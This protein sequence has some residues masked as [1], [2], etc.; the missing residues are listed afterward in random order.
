MAIRWQNSFSIGFLTAILCVY[1]HVCKTSLGMTFATPLQDK[2]FVQDKGNILQFYNCMQVIEYFKIALL[3]C[4]HD[5]F[6]QTQYKY[7]RDVS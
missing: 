1:T 7:Y 6:L 2:S 5:R 3:N 4:I